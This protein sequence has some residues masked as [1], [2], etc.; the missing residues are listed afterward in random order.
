MKYQYKISTLK[1]G[2]NEIL[3]FN[4]LGISG[5]STVVTLINDILWVDVGKLA[6]D[7]IYRVLDGS[8]EFGEF[9]TEACTAQI[10]KEFTKVINNFSDVTD[11]CLIE[12]IELKYLIE[13]WVEAKIRFEQK[14]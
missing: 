9:E 5:L 12:T 2:Q 11:K 14:F 3:V 13:K 7:E 8:A 6:L 10:R 4:L 1:I